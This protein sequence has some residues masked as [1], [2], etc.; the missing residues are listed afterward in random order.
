MANL[1]SY[2]KGYQYQNIARTILYE[3]SFLAE[4]VDIVNDIGADFYCTYYDINPAKRNKYLIPKSSF[5]IQIKSSNTR[6]NPIDITKYIHIIKNME[7]PFFIGKVNQDRFTLQIYS[8]ELLPAFF[9]FKGFQTNPP[10]NL[11]AELYEIPQ[12]LS[13]HWLNEKDWSHKSLTDQNCVTFPRIATLCLPTTKEKT[14]KKAKEEIKKEREI[15]NCEIEKIKKRITVVYENLVSYNAKEF[16]FR[17]ATYPDQINWINISNTNRTDILERNIDLRLAE[18]FFHIRHFPMDSV[19]NAIDIF[20]KYENI[21][22][23]L[24][25][26]RTVDPLLTQNYEDAHKNISEIKR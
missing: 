11:F 19:E 13:G 2:R 15:I 3:F 14:A 1:Y 9:A 24:I 12:N 25:S 8:G 18:L 10:N 7:L 16:I 17:D 21:Y 26:Y 5:L 22:H 4:P 6:V 23:S 20:N